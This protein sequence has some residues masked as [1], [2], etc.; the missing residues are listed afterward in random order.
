MYQTPLPLRHESSNALCSIHGVPL[1]CGR[2]NSVKGLKEMCSDT[3]NI[4]L[5]S[6]GSCREWNPALKPRYS[7]WERDISTG[8]LCPEEGHE[9]FQISRRVK[10]VVCLRL[11]TCHRHKLNLPGISKCGE[12]VPRLF[13]RMKR[14]RL[15]SWF[16]GFHPGA[17]TWFEVCAQRSL[18]Y[19]ICFG[20]RQIHGRGVRSCLHPG[21]KPRALSRCV[22]GLCGV[23]WPQSSY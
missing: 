12:D 8:L 9:E 17:L 4:F 3:G 19:Q 5:F 16:S 21:D 10:G 11:K 6:A 15:P 23:V 1:L 20:L 13:W 14:G 22:K 2:F 7:P 18:L